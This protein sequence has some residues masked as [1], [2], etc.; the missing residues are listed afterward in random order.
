MIKGGWGA[1]SVGQVNEGITLGVGASERMIP[2]IVYIN[3]LF[4]ASS[5][6]RMTRR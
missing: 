5:T 4:I 1:V 6:D 3:E 2:Q